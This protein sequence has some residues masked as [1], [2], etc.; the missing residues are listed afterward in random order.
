VGLIDAL[1]GRFDL[2]LCEK[3]DCPR[4]FKIDGCTAE[5]CPLDWGGR[6]A[7]KFYMLDAQG[8]AGF[9][10][11]MYRSRSMK[12]VTFDIN[13]TNG[14]TGA[15]E[16]GFSLSGRYPNMG[17][18]SLAAV[19]GF[20]QRT[21]ETCRKMKSGSGD[22]TVTLSATDMPTL[23]FPKVDWKEVTKSERDL[24]KEAE[25]VISHAEKHH[26]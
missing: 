16:R 25:K 15:D 17:D 9:T 20:M 8:E 11:T 22:M 2:E 6:G 12:T 10:G 19:T 14:K 24:L 4:M 26:A 7:I 18:D 13:A 23:T 1:L 21:G 5:S 3:R